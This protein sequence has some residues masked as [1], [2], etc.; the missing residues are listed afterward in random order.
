MRTEIQAIHFKADQELKDFIVRKLEKL[1]KY[2][3]GIMSSQVYL[4]VNNN[5][6][7]KNKTVEIKVNVQNQSLMK[8]QTSESFE[9]ATDVAVDTLAT[10]VKRYKEKLQSVA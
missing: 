2:Y 3:D 7:K 4:K 1:T 8:T 6:G 5:H 9:A 10:Q